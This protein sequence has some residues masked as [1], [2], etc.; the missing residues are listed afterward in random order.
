MT[1]IQIIQLLG[2]AYFSAGLGAIINPGLFKKAINDYM[3]NLAAVYLSAFL[4]LTLGYL[5]ANRELELCSPVSLL[6]GAIGWL[7]LVK[8]ILILLFPQMHVNLLKFVKKDSQLFLGTII[9]ILI[10]AAFLFI[11]L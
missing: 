7:A 8:G 11:S 5:L 10:G 4:V 2:L 6:V 9:I 1:D 3:E